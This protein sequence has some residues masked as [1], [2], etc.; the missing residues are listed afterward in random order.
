[1]NW[2]GCLLIVASFGEADADFVQRVIPIYGDQA[3]SPWDDVYQTFY[4]RQFTT[5]EKY[6]HRLSFSPP[7][8]Q[9][10]GLIDDDK[11]YSQVLQRL[12]QIAG[13]PAS[14]MEEAAP[15]RRL[16]F[17][18]DLWTVSDHLQKS[19]EEIPKKVRERRQEIV[20]RL[21]LI[22]RRL[23]LTEAEVAALPN[24]L[25]QTQAEK[26]FPAMFD[27]DKPDQA[28]V[29]PD[30]LDDD[31]KWVTIKTSKGVAHGAPHH[32][33]SVDD[34]SLF[35]IHLRLPAGGVTPDE[36]IA[37]SHK[38]NDV[39]DFPPGTVLVLLRRA[40]AP[41]DD[42]RLKVTN[43]V[44]SLQT[45]VIPEKT[46]RFTRFAKL[47]LDRRDFAQGKTG[48]I[49]L[50]RK[51]PVDAYGFESAGQWS[52]R[53]AS[54][55]DGEP[56]VLGKY[57]GH[58]GVPSLEHCTACHGVSRGALFANFSPFRSYLSNNGEL[59]SGVEEAKAKS[60]SWKE[61]LR[62]RQNKGARE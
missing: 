51:T 27:R 59:A 49:P 55:A 56:L 29:P 4:V 1:M 24:T 44:E 54:D 10:T 22:M 13:L 37:A 61:Y 57:K 42:G 35:S 21:A 5:G 17:F 47:I 34:R 58:G 12:E 19:R 7:S 50:T 41:L 14:A 45:I 25:K 28:F 2:I 26:L 62:L 33:Q 8:F 9:F 43:V 11:A 6:Y 16:L 48:L 3:A 40:I 18:R 30:L 53:N 38:K 46:D 60:E 15:T 20:R 39:F 32:Q 23:E 52:M 31:T 36:L